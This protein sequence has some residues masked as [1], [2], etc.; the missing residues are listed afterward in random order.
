MTSAHA[1]AGQPVDADSWADWKWQQRNAIRSARQLAAYFPDCPPELLDL[2][3]RHT[4]TRRFQVTPYYL[5]LVEADSPL[6]RPRSDDPLWL[7]VCPVESGGVAPYS[8]DG[9]TENWEL[10]H[11]M[12][13][14]IAQHKYDNRIIVRYSNVCQAY[15]QFCYEALRTLEKDSTKVSFDP[16]HWQA[17]LRFVGAHRDIEEVILSGGE[18]LMH[19]DEQIDR[20]LGQLRDVRPD[21]VLRI[22]TRALTF[23]PFRITPGLVAAFERHR[24]QAIGVHVT[25][26]RELT[27]QF[28]TS[29]RALQSA[30]PIVF[31][32]VPLLGNV[33]ATVP[34]MRQ[35]C[36]GLYGLG[37]HAG[38]LYHFMP[39]S[40]EGEL[41]RVPVSHGVAIVRALRR[42][43]SNPA[44]P[45]YVLA[46]ATGKFTV[47]LHD[48]EEV[49]V[50]ID[51]QHGNQV[52]SFVNWQ[53]TRVSYPDAA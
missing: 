43:I 26:P 37:V 22:H 44:V 24:V 11:E 52:L 12:V 40:P 28:A 6:R 9:E 53:G 51:D 5:G 36:M 19:S 7:Q 42:R 32:N 41:F 47:P 27:D 1:R 49:P 3:G 29:V 46:H 31:A 38:Y 39:H 18:P 14:P 2:I 35:L 45:E 8:Y 10:P 21:L 33:N 16:N 20:V 15:C 17:T 23:N 34:V 30:V 13:T 25:H 4:E 50:R 48:P